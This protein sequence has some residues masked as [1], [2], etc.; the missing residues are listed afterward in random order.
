MKYNLRRVVLLVLDM[1]IYAH[2]RMW[3]EAIVQT[4]IKIF[5][6]SLTG[7]VDKIGALIRFDI[8]MYK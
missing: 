1:N 5:K 3:Y 4:L 6:K 7:K 2:M 8:Y